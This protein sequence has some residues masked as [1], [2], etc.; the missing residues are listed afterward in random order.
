MS[1]LV[2]TLCCLASN[3]IVERGGGGAYCALFARPPEIASRSVAPG[4]A[5]KNGGAG[6]GAG[7]NR[8]ID[9]PA[10]FFSK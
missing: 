6:A 8:K 1:A 3:H 4:E 2:T 5:W 7:L 10:Y 9:K